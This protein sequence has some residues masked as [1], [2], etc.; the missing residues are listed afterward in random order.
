[1]LLASRLTR[2]LPAAGLAA[3]C[4]AA[5]GCERKVI[6]E[7]LPTGSA[8]VRMTPAPVAPIGA[9][10][11]PAR[12]TPVPVPGS[13][14]PAGPSDPSNGGGAD[15]PNNTAPVVEVGAHFFFAE[16]NGSVIGYDDYAPVG[17]RIHLDATAKDASRKPTQAKGPPQWSFAGDVG[18]VS[19]NTYTSYTPALM[20]LAP[21]R[22]TAWCTID[23]VESNRFPLAFK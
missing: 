21:A 7:Q 23:G 20:G 18:N 9:A 4:L 22:L 17:C 2:W 10:P 14:E 3:M 11:G 19:V 8:D 15:I 16:C 6:S 13:S 5:V 12:P 1:M